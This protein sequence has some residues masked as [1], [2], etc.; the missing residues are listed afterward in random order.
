MYCAIINTKCERNTDAM[1][2][3][4]REIL[5]ESTPEVEILSESV[6]VLPMHWHSF[7][8]KFYL[9]LAAAY[10]LFQA[11]W[12][13]FGNI[14]IEAAARES[15]YASMPGMQIA[16]YGFAGILAVVSVLQLLACRKLA[17]KKLAGIALLKGAYI[18]LTLAILV[19]LPARL[20]ISGMPLLNL[21]LLGQAVS[22]MALL[23]INRSYYRKR[24][25]AFNP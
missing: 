19:Y 20:L 25:N 7:L 15:I 8:V 18:L 5:P 24:R 23:W 9:W 1:S 4:A 10:H 21:P 14:Y 13:V 17:K 11:A 2:E 3:A 6:P 22:Y 12:M 16:D